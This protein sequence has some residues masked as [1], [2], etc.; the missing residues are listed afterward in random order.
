MG[1]IAW[2]RVILGGLVAG[3]LWFAFEGFVHGFLLGQGWHAAMAALGRSEEQMQ[4]GNGRFMFLVTIWSFLAGI[5][6]VWLYAAIRPRFGPGPKT[7][8]IAG[9]GLWVMTYLAPSIVDYAFNLWPSELVL[10]PLAT[11]FFESII[12]TLVGARLYK[13]A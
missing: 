12:A 7:G 3:I 4:A 1:K 13:E 9:I 5:A 2:G 8:V 10:M 11:S 6:G